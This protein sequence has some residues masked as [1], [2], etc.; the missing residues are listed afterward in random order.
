MRVL[1]CDWQQAYGMTEA[2]P[3]VTSLSA[4]DHRRGGA[5]QQP[6]A[7]RLRSA[8]VPVVGVEA[9]VRRSDGTHADVDEP[10][11]I[12]V[13]GPNI[14]KDWNRPRKPMEALDPDGWYR[15][16][17][18]AYRDEDGYLY[19][20]DRVKDMI[21]SGG[22]HGSAPRSR[23]RSTNTPR[24]SNAPSSASP[25]TAGANASTPRLS[26]NQTRAQTQ[27]RSSI[28]AARSSPATSFLVR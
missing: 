28:I 5:G 3:L 25:T 20:V 6:Y 7:R 12:W 11:E 1:P 23:T 21:V 22:G 4:E 27:T 8:G 14:M 10:G 17:D 26:S 19:V 16:G 2:A 9:E 18:A 13:R 15:F 24:C